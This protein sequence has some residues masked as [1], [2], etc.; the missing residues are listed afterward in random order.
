MS[1]ELEL[2]MW[3]QPRVADYIAKMCGFHMDNNAQ[4]QESACLA[5]LSERCLSWPL[6]L[7]PGTS[8]LRGM[9]WELGGASW[10]LGAGN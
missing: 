6:W 1:L 9:S 3:L 4:H 2:E 5:I 8:A 7:E 10:E